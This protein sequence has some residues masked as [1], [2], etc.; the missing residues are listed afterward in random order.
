MPYSVWKYLTVIAPPGM[1]IR[2]EIFSCLN[3]AEDLR[4][5]VFG[6]IGIRMQMP[7]APIAWGRSFSLFISAALW[8]GV[9]GGAGG[10]V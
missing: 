3:M 5:P 6:R 2:T 4:I 7:I 8:G 1:F 9:V 10:V